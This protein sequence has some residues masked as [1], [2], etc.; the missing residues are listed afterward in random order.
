[1]RPIL[2]LL[3]VLLLNASFIPTPAPTADMPASGIRSYYM[4]YL[5]SKTYRDRLKSFGYTCIDTVIMERTVSLV[6]V[7]YG[8]SDSTDSQYKDTKHT[9]NISWKQ[10]LGSSIAYETCVA[11]EYSHACGSLAS[12]NTENKWLPLNQYEEFQLRMRNK[13]TF[14]DTTKPYLDLLAIYHDRRPC[15]SKADL[16]AFRYKLFRDGM[17]DVTTDTFTQ[18][19]LRQSHQLYKKDFIIARLF[20]NFSDE[21]IIYLMNNIP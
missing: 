2:T 10:L 4:T 5:F 21:D 1:M 7:V 19:I 16:D 20:H 15:E 3:L 13:L 8:E 9:I 12:N 11:H 18:K 6:S 17:Y 14:I